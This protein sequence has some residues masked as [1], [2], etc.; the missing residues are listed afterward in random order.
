MNWVSSEVLP[1][2]W[3]LL[4]GFVASWVFAGLTAYPKLSEFER[5]VEALIFT[6]FAQT[7]TLLLKIVLLAV[8][9]RGWI[10]GEWSD[11]SGRAWSVILG[12]LLGFL[13]AVAANR[14]FVHRVLRPWATMLTGYPSEWFGVLKDRAAT[15][16]VVLHL[17]NERRLYGRVDEWPTDP[18]K[19]HFSIWDA[20]WLRPDGTSIPL[21]VAR[22]LVPAVEVSF[23][24]FKELT[25]GTS[26]TADPTTAP[27]STPGPDP[28]PTGRSRDSSAG[29]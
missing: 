26:K 12:A 4:P 8:G 13:F 29:A 3:F 9:A 11:D 1:I 16:A 20:E 17:P 21:G 7:S 24:E 22:I 10:V 28:G 6:A 19:G 5:V 18:K 14:D 2:L 23:I 25:H 27:V 15:H